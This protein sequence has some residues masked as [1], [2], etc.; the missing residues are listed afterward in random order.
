VGNFK[1]KDDIE[2]PGINEKRIPRD[3]NMNL[4]KAV[5]VP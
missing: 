2:D 1:E 4:E 3:R 5:R